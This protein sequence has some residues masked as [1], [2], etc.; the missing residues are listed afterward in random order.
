VV[1]VEG[2]SDKAALSAVARLM[3][4]SF[5]AAGIALLSAEGKENLDR[6]LV[7]F[8]SLGI[9]TYVVWDC[10]EGTKDAKPQTDLALARLC[11][12]DAQDV[13]HPSGTRVEDCYAHFAVTLERTLKDEV[14]AARHA[15]CLAAACE[16]FGITPSKDS[17]KIPEVVYRMMTAARDDGVEFGTLTA[18]IEAIWLHILGEQPEAGQVNAIAPGALVAG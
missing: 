13:A 2:R 14:G 16:P 11:R 6:P 7:I 8:R 1:L 3:G 4:R 17:Q 10:D 18:M 15:A 5:E 9:P 12:P